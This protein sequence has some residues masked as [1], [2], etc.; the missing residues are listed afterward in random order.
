M[1]RS[2]L[3]GE[4]KKKITEIKTFPVQFPLVEKKEKK[5]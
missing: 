1:D 3:E 2:S 5:S 4:L